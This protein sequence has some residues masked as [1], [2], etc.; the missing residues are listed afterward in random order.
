MASNVNGEVADVPTGPTA[1][2]ELKTLLKDENGTTR[3]RGFVDMLVPTSPLRGVG[4]D[5]DLMD[6]AR[7]ISDHFEMEDGDT[8]SDDGSDDSSGVGA[9]AHGM[10]HGTATLAQVSSKYYVGCNMV[11]AFIILIS[12][13]IYTLRWQ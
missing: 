8:Y 6:E 3:G 11:H 10:A 12:I 1:T 9:G 4:D 5:N 7:N 13:I 2:R